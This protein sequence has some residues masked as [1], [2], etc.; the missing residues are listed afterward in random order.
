MPKTIS[1]LEDTLDVVDLN[2]TTPINQGQVV[3]Q[4][5][6]SVDNLTRNNSD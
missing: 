5:P 1:Q 6:T 4:P 2:D 3:K